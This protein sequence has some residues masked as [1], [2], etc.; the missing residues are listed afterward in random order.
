MGIGYQ[1]CSVS[2]DSHGN[3]VSAAESGAAVVIVAVK[4]NRAPVRDGIGDRA[5]LAKL[6]FGPF[7]WVI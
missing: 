7:C 4:G 6:L 1:E 2:D 5:F 3:G